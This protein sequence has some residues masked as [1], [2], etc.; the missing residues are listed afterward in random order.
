MNGTAKWVG[1]TILLASVFLPATGVR[2]EPVTLHAVDGVTVFANHE[3]DG[4]P[5]RPIILLFHQAGGSGAEY[6]AIV[7]RLVALGYDTLA[8]DQRSG[9]PAF[10]RP[11]RTV[12][13]LGRSMGY[14]DALPDL[15]AAVDWAAARHPAAIVAWGSSYSASLVLLLAERE[16]RVSAI[17]SFSPGEYFSDDT[18]VRRSA[19]HVSVPV[20]LS[21]ASAPGEIAQAA[22]ILAVLPG[23]AKVQLR[24]RH[25]AH[26]SIA[27]AGPGAADIWPGVESFLSSVTTARP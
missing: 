1:A 27:L 23:K 26:G 19:S 14:L 22:E 13:R 15:Q 6:D 2:A 9:G 4:K 21:S 25:A 11:N 18:W 20:L 3:G 10:G 8:V 7:P 12:Q 16:A 24:P 5:G 17:V